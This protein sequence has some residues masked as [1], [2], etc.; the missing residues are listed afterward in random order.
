MFQEADTIK[1]YEGAIT[2]VRTACGETWVSSDCK[3]ALGL[4][5]IIENKKKQF[6]RKLSCHEV[7]NCVFIEELTPI[8]ATNEI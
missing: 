5:F 3:F 1:T 4:A 8:W 2:S 6:A 7:V